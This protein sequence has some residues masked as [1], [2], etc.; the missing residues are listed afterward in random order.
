MENNIIEF[1]DLKDDNLIITNIQIVDGRKIIHAQKKLRHEY[2]PIC[3]SR[4]HSRGT[5]RTIFMS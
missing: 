3:S 5:N 4:M 1:L 2:C